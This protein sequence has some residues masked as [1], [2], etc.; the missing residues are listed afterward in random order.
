MHEFIIQEILFPLFVPAHLLILVG[1]GLLIGQQG[2]KHIWVGIPVFILASVFGLLLTR[3]FVLDWNSETTLLIFTAFTGILLAWRLSVPV[4]LLQIL[5]AA[6]GFLIGL[7]SSPSMIP[8]MQASIIYTI[9]AGTVVVSTLAILL[10]ALISVALRHVLN[11][12][13]LRVIGSWVTASAVMVLTLMF[14]S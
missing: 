7:G 13:I 14:A 6:I 4:W 3:F 9:L 2:M 11:S 8:G 10:F 1:L 12:L 5:V